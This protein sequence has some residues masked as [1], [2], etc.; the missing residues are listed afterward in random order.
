MNELKLQKQTVCKTSGKS[1][2]TVKI[3]S[4]RGVLEKLI[5]E[6]QDILKKKELERTDKELQLDLELK[7][8]SLS[9]RMEMTELK[10]G[11]KPVRRKRFDENVSLVIIW[12][13]QDNNE[14]LMAKVKDLLRPCLR[15]N[16]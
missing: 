2:R 12:L 4:L 16:A 7:V 6:S 1:K 11:E 9:F 8:G 3:D 5:S 15:P 13:R 10:M 14:D